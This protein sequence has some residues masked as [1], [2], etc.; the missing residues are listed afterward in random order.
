MQLSQ[1]QRI[2]STFF[3]ISEIKVN[4]EYFQKKNDPNSLCIFDRTDSQKHC[5]KSSLSEN[6]STSNMVEGPKH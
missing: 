4:F 3:C 6:P 5:L 2:F 1:K